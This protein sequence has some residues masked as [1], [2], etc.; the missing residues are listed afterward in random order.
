[1]KDLRV[2]QN[3]MI[4]LEFYGKMGNLSVPPFGTVLDVNSR[5]VTIEDIYGHT[6]N[7]DK[8][9]LEDDNIADS[10]IKNGDKFN[11]KVIKNFI[12]L[13]ENEEDLN[14]IDEKVTKYFD[15]KL[16]PFDSDFGK[17][18]TVFRSIE[19][20]AQFSDFEE[21]AMAKVEYLY[22][23]TSSYMEEK[24]G[25]VEQKDDDK[26]SKDSGLRSMGKGDD[27]KK[28]NPLDYLTDMT[29]QAKENPYDKAYGREKEIKEVMRFIKHRDKKNA[30]LVGKQGCGKTSIIEELANR[31]AAGEIPALKGKKILAMDVDGMIAGT[32]YR[33]MFEERC[34]AV[35]TYCA[36]QKDVIVFIDEVHKIMGAG[37]NTE[38]GMNLGNLMKTYLTKGISVIGA[39]TYD[40]YDNLKDDAAL[41]RRF[42]IVTIDEQEPEVV[43]WILEQVKENYEDFHNVKVTNTLLNAIVDTF[44]Q[45]N[46]NTAGID[47]AKN[48]LDS[49][50]T[51]MEM[52]N[53]PQSKAYAEFIESQSY[54]KNEDNQ[55]VKK[56]KL[57]FCTGIVEEKE[58]DKDG[59]VVEEHVFAPEVQAYIDLLK[60][61]EET[62][63]ALMLEEENMQEELVESTDV[64]IDDEEEFEG[65]E[66]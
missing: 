22:E 29:K 2:G 40:E 9:Y 10:D 7:V 12:Q 44:D 5:I 50:C 46:Y 43:K 65:L 47:Y 66:R 53:V 36:T 24:L 6:W 31:V 15:S 21:N 58:L 63:L 32:K 51:I 56:A 54:D 55:Y 37:G 61:E 45:K 1:M 38:G 26:Y 8:I 60:Q 4:S 35:L 14:V 33:G 23:L 41:A 59:A 42:G 34:K 39:T 19:K 3:V 52:D 30:I 20:Y 11:D 48:A 16:S 62:E 13:F 25:V 49:I 64:L 57:G 18:L 27:E 17:I 28:V